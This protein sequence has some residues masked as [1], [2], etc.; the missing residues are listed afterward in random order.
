[1][2][3][4]AT[5]PL[6]GSAA[7]FVVLVRASSAAHPRLA[8]TFCAK[9]ALSPSAADLEGAVDASF[10]QHTRALKRA[11]RKRTEGQRGRTDRLDRLSKSV[12]PVSRV[13][14]RI[15]RLDG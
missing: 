9:P 14:A 5:G 6:G 10:G 7:V 15:G 3:V 1:M 4:V 12:G 2:F 13:F 8:C 11:S